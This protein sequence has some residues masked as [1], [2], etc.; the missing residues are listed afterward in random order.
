[1]GV[2]SQVQIYNLR[3]KKK[4]KS[5]VYIFSSLIQASVFSVFISMRSNIK[6]EIESLNICALEKFFF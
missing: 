2:V 3:W 5:S 4:K 1:M 6:G